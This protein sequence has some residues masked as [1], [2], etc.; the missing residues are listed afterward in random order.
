MDEQNSLTVRFEVFQRAQRFF[1][2]DEQAA[3]GLVVDVYRRVFEQF[4]G[5]FAKAT[6]FLK[7]ELA[8]IRDLEQFE[9]ESDSWCAIKNTTPKSH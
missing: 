5:S 1:H 6:K 3:G 9:K 7:I 4:G 8:I 2:G